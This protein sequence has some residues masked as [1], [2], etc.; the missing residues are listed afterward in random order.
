MTQINETGN[1]QVQFA[2]FYLEGLLFGIDVMQVQEIIR[3][4]EMTPAPLS[5]AEVEGLINLRGQIITAIDLRKRL[6]M[7]NREDAKLPMNVVV[8]TE[9]GTVS[10][11]VDEIGDVLE[12]ENGSFE[13][14]PTTVPD[15]CR[16]F[17][18]GVY[19]LEDKLLLTLDTEKVV[20][21]QSV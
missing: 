2:T 6:S 8:R 16:A 13:V 18:N 3:Y 10:L 11:L 20:D 12:V 7:S 5:S 14:P 9:D 17:I 19:K 21:V 1:T 15:S 4:Q